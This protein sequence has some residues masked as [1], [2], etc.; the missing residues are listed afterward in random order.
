MKFHEIPSYNKMKIK[1]TKKDYPLTNDSRTVSR[2]VK[3][4]EKVVFY[5]CLDIYQPHE[6]HTRGQSVMTFLFCE[7]PGVS[8]I[9]FV[10]FEIFFNAEM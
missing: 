9:F 8:H 2:N 1:I 7:I 4:L 10:T 5:F 3:I 6:Q